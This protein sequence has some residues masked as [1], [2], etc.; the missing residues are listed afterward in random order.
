[1]D[2]SCLLA[3]YVFHILIWIFVIFGGFV[4]KNICKSILFVFVPVIYIVHTLPFHILLKK[5]LEMINNNLE[6]FGEVDRELDP[7]LANQ[8]MKSGPPNISKERSM[9]I[10]KVYF[11]EE[12]KLIIPGIHGKICGL[13]SSSFANPLSPQGLLILAMIINTYVLR[14]YWKD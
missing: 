1:M 7:E 11:A 12:D 9:A 3:I 8:L 10:A 2:K 5:K 6:S 4:S 13:F 14:F